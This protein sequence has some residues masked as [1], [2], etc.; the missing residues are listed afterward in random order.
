M[1]KNIKK[2]VFFT[3]ILLLNIVIIDF[4]HAE[5]YNN[6]TSSVVSCGED[7]VKNIPSLFPKTISIIYNLIQIVVPI[8]LVVFGSIDLVK[9]IVAQKEDDIKNG[10]RMFVKRLIVAAIIFFV[11]VGVKMIISFVAD[12]NSNRIIDCTD[13]FIRN[14]CTSKE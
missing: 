11:F 4:V 3:I 5:T 12:N 1:K 8:L 9:G 7:L 2:I 13:C 10:Q 6:Y 14:K